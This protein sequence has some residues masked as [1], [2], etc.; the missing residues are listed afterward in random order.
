MNVYK[1]RVLNIAR[2]LRESPNPEA[3]DMSSVVD[4]ACG[5]P[6]CA[7]GHYAARADLQDAFW[8]G[9]HSCEALGFVP[10]YRDTG[11]FVE[12]NGVNVQLHFGLSHDEINAMFGGGSGCGRARTALDAAKWL[13]AFAERKWPAKADDSFKRFL[14]AALRPVETCSAARSAS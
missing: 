2:A 1:Q 3:F 4:S 5:T 11:R 6:Y 7:F 8:V 10:M 12:F 13:E 9:R 14:S